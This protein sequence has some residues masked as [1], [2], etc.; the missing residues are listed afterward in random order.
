M[1][2]EET[3]KLKQ[4]IGFCE[5]TQENIDVL[6]W[7]IGE[8]GDANIPETLAFSLDDASDELRSFITKTEEATGI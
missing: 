2:E 3:R 7:K 1:S 5:K 8:H 6:L 4:L